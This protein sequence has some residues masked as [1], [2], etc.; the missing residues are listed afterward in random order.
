MT[1]R[2][3]TVFTI[4]LYIFCLNSPRS[5][6]LETT[7][8]DVRQPSTRSEAMGKAY[9]SIDGD[10]ACKYYNPAGIATLEGAQ[11]QGSLAYPFYLEPK[12][13]FSFIGT[14]YRFNKYLTFGISLNHFD[15]G[16]ELYFTDGDGNIIGSTHWSVSDYALTMASEPIKNL[17]IGVNANYY[18][19]KMYPKNPKIFY[20]D[21]GA[22]K[23]LPI[24]QTENLT[25]MLNFG[26]SIINF[27]NTKL[28]VLD[29]YY[30]KIP[31][32]TRVGANYQ[33]ILH[34]ST[35]TDK[36]ETIS[37]LYQFDYQYIINSD[38]NSAIQTGGECLFFELLALR[39][40]Y[41]SEKV[42]DYDIPDNF[43]YIS[44][45]TYGIGIQVPLNKLT[46]IPMKLSI[47]YTNLPQSEY[48]KTSPIFDNFTSFDVRL[49]WIFPE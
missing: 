27:S 39:F 46:K 30:N 4:I 2:G 34:K 25:H 12:A 22:I 20:F 26:A 21:F 19:A 15:A 48:S 38:Y 32:I 41:Y 24:Y 11:L 36:L 29:N 47:D 42:N 43:D 17:L 6:S 18:S 1:S 9:A 7:L 28:E 10:L 13:K 3:R 16:E 45:F 33:F 31:M 37:F 23:K 35:L 49:N 40:G 5:Q 8:F 44:A 14:G